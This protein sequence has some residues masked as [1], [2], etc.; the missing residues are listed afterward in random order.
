MILQ[1]LAESPCISGVNMGKYD[2]I[3]EELTKI[4]SYCAHTIRYEWCV[5]CRARNLIQ[6]LRGEE[7]V[8]RIRRL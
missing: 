6:Y 3:I 1:T 5:G 8:E 7:Y 2:K 4:A